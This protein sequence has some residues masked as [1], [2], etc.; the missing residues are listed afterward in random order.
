MKR[1]LCLLFLLG[2]LLPVYG[3]T[4]YISNSRC[5]E[6]DRIE[7]LNGNAGILLLSRCNDLIVNVP[8]LSNGVSPIVEYKGERPD[9]YHE[10]IVA[11]P[12]NET[13]TPKIEAS[14]R[15]IV[16]KVEFTAR[17]KPDYLVAY[18][19]E[20]V[21][22][23]IRLDNQTKGNDVHTNAQEAAVEFATVIKDMKVVCHPDLKA[24]IVTAPGKADPNVKV[25]LVT[26]PIATLKAAKDKIMALHNEITK[27][28]N[29]LND[30]KNKNLATD[31][32]W[33]R[34][35]DLEKQEAEANVYCKTISNIV[36]SV[37]ESNEL[38]INV[39]DYTPR[40]KT[41]YV[42]V[43]LI[44]EKTVFVT[45]CSSYMSQGAEL[46]KSRKYKDAQQ[47]YVS[48]LNAKD[49]IEGMQSA[50]K[51]SIAQCDSCIMYDAYAGMALH[52]LKDLRKDP[53]ATQ[54][55][56]TR[57]ATAAIDFIKMLSNYNPDPYYAKIIANIESTL[58]Y[59][60]LKIK[61]T[62]VQWKTLNEGA[63][64][65][66]L[67]IWAYTGT[68]NE[69]EKKLT[70]DRKFRRLKDSE[71]H[72]L[73]QIA[74]TDARGTAEVELKR[75]DLPE[76]L[77]FRPMDGSGVKFKYLSIKDLF[78]HA[79]GTYFKKQFRLRLFTKAD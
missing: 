7:D 38:S 29:F 42:V 14:R 55:E 39:S 65:G 68:N 22:H 34:L 45:E 64:I 57:Y 25:T 31:E 26:F 72:L 71:G 61:F 58:E 40:M 48:A 44:I 62:V 15:G 35:E 50:I 67:E 21:P 8:N 75:T 41:S 11:I 23:P 79:Q 13:N 24:E 47:A 18:R 63:P 70:S 16:F 46:F 77:I 17:V 10:Y 74:V 4:Q 52:K 30:E 3:Q 60:P 20:E 5:E 43:P 36:I 51:T 56:V 12:K 27:L 37:K 1:I 9:G 76:G 19:L 53:N 66:N 69:L 33:K 28:E 32:K 59:M 49:M 73:Y 6:E 54:N 2:L 78:K